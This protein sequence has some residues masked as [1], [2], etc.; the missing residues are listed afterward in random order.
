MEATSE[1]DL[2][3]E[4]KATGFLWQLHVRD[5]QVSLRSYSRKW[6]VAVT[7]QKGNDGSS[8]Q[9]WEKFLLAVEPEGFVDSPVVEDR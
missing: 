8:D 3:C 7:V 9:Q 4:R 5:A 2:E 1:H 6:E